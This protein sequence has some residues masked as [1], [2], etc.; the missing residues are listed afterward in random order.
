[1]KLN[2]N[3]RGAVFVYQPLGKSVRF[4][5]GIVKHLNLQQLTRIVDFAGLL[6]QALDDIALVVNGKLCCDAGQERETS[7]WLFRQIPAMFHVAADHF[8]AVKTVHRKDQEDNEIGDQHCPIEKFEV[9]D[10]GKRI[11]EHRVHQARDSVGRGCECE[12]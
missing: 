4:I 11:V 8:I 9:V 10:V 3:A 12:Q 1:M 6:N 5:G 7:A 2:G